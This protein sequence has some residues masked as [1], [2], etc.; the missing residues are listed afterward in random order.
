MES[1]YWVGPIFIKAPDDTVEAGFEHSP[2]DQGEVDIQLHIGAPFDVPEAQLESIA[3]AISFSVLS[4]VN[5]ALEDLLVPVAPIQ[6][7]RL[8]EQRRSSFENEITVAV[9][10]R[11]QF[12]AELL[13][14]KLG[15]FVGLRLQMSEEEKVALDAA[16]RRYLT[17][18]T[19]MDA[20]DKFCDLWEACEF[21]THDVKAK[22]G[23]VGRISQMLTKHMERAGIR[24]KKATV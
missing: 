1:G 2:P 18:L 7:R 12:S 15:N 16:M 13:E 5:V 6:I 3:S 22:G 23:K 9:R 11:K 4:Y 8:L 17:S 21:A 14:D 24:R 19:E 20:V 10:E